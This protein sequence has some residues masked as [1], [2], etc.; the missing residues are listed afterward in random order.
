MVP[1]KFPYRYLRESR[2]PVTS[3]V[4]Y[5]DWLRKELQTSTP[6]PICPFTGAEC[7]S[8]YCV[9]ACSGCN[10]AR[11]AFSTAPSATDDVTAAEMAICQAVSG[12]AAAESAKLL[13]SPSAAV[14]HSVRMKHH[15]TH[16]TLVLNLYA[17]CA[18]DPLPMYLCRTLDCEKLFNDFLAERSAKYRVKHFVDNAFST[19]GAMVEIQLLSNMEEAA[20]MEESN[21]I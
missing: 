12:L 11:Y 21:G 1:I 7:E 18:D 5:L 8:A 16:S 2:S 19:L 13:I 17:L 4:G 9:S 6:E 20:R 14:C 15:G 10:V 3:E